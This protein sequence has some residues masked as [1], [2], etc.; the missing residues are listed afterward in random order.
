M[1]LCPDIRNSLS[2]KSYNHSVS[3]LERHKCRFVTMLWSQFVHR[4]PGDTSLSVVVIVPMTPSTFI[5][6]PIV[7]LFFDR[8]LLWSSYTYPK[9][10]VETDLWFDTYVIH[11]KMVWKTFDTLL[12]SK[13]LNIPR[14]FT[15]LREVHPTPPE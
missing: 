11:S 4:H 10:K 13:I 12:I 14:P 7:V 5:P 9:G 8:S 15:I 6:R 1:S 2:Y 3:G